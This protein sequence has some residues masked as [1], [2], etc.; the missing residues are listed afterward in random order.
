MIFAAVFQAHK[1]RRTKQITR[2]WIGSVSWVVCSW[3][4]TQRNVTDTNTFFKVFGTLKN[5]L[6]RQITKRSSGFVLIAIVVQDALSR[7][8]WVI[9]LGDMVQWGFL[10][11]FLK[12]K[13]VYHEAS[14]PRWIE[15]SL[16]NSW[17]QRS[18]PLSSFIHDSQWVWPSSFRPT[19]RWYK[20][21]T[22][23]LCGVDAFLQHEMKQRLPCTFGNLFRWGACACSYGLW[24]RVFLLLLK[25]DLT[26][27][28]YSHVIPGSLACSLSASS[29]RQS[30][31][32][33]HLAYSQLLAL[34]PV[35]AAPHI[36][37]WTTNIIHRPT[38]FPIFWIQYRNCRSVNSFSDNCIDNHW[39]SL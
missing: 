37:P 32:C 3:T 19:K 30:G 8:I 29:A 33:I 28:L 11:P 38:Q 35:N 25:I 18:K 34:L 1:P 36:Q 2:T 24:S 17:H 5:L 31:D 4:G 21:Y 16:T 20:S 12:A 39:E 27:L 10:Y 23:G 26:E 22:D 9:L 7:A 13:A 6:L 15:V 14:R